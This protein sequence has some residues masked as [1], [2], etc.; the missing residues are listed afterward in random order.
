[1]H[2]KLGRHSAS[3]FRMPVVGAHAEVLATFYQAGENR[4][5]ATDFQLNCVYVACLCNPPQHRLGCGHILCTE[6]VKDFG[7]RNGRQVTIDG[8]PLH[9]DPVTREVNKGTRTVVELS[10]AFSGLRVLT[11]DG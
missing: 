3:E 7:S 10:P 4:A 5:R 6:Y 9:D 1:M 11:L 2:Q 8:C